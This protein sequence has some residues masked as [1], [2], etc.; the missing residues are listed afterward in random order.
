MKWIVNDAVH[1]SEFDA[2]DKAALIEHLNDQDIHAKL[3]RVPYPYTAGDADEW[4]EIV[5][6][7]TQQQG[8]PV[9]FAIRD[10]GGVLIGGCG[11]N[12]I[13][14][15][16]SHK[17]ELGYWLA[18]SRWGQGIMSDVVRRLCRYGFEELG[19]VKVTAHVFTGNPASARV[20]EKCG[21]VREGLLRQHFKKGGDLLDVWLYANFAPS[22]PEKS[23]EIAP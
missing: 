13:D 4:L 23:T 3:L 21:F 20:L 12:D 11:Y 22:S 10:R 17:A 16:K 6:K 9:N 14:V 5:A 1:L 8:R 7:R 15:G 19:L 2:R 18:K